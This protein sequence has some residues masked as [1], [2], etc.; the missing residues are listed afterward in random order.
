VRQITRWEANVFTHILIAT[1]GSELAEKAA[2]Q[3]LGLASALKAKVLA[4]TVTEPRIG[5]HHPV[6]ST[7]EIDRAVAEIADRITSQ[8]AEVAKENNV[9]CST[10]H[11]RDRHPAE[12]ILDAAQKNGC[13][14]IVMA[15]HGRRG[16]G[17]V[18]LG[19]ITTEVLVRST[20][21]VLVCR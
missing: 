15:S 13:D 2:A 6:Q 21:P 9:A 18:V 10:L 14:L 3:G 4:V 11:V 5:G 20:I 17:R 8:V 7:I 16:L 12:G 19:S 1:D